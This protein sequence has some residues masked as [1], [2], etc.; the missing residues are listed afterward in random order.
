MHR[1]NSIPHLKSLSDLEASYPLS[2]QGECSW[3]V[4]NGVKLCHLMSSDL[5]IKIAKYMSRD[6]DKWF[7]S[8]YILDYV[9][10]FGG[11][12]GPM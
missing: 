7:E 2:S 3:T 6:G 9:L 8:K 11:V 10:H 5:Y 1:R 4:A 12:E